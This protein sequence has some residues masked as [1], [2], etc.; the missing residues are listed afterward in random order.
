MNPGDLLEAK[1]GGTFRKVL[2]VSRF[3]DAVAE[4]VC[5]EFVPDERGGV[6]LI[7]VTPGEMKGWRTPSG[8]DGAEHLRRQ[9]FDGR[10]DAEKRLID[11]MA[12]TIGD[13]IRSKLQGQTT[14]GFEIVHAIL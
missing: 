9:F 10:P 12:G 6:R 3:M 8:T 1:T 11:A 4:G 13:K 7:V 2:H 5:L 14:R